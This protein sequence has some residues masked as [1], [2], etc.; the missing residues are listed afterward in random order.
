MKKTALLILC[1]LPLLSGCG[2]LRAQ[3]REVEQLRLA[4]TLGLDPAP[5]GLILSLAAPGGSEES[6]LFVR[7]SGPTVE[8]AMEALR[9]RSAEQELFCGHLQHILLGEAFAE[10]G[11]DA[12]LAAVCRSP[13]LR[14]DM[15]VYLVL[16]AAAGDAMEQAEDGETGVCDLLNGLSVRGGT[17]L[18][19]AGR[20]LRDLDR[21]GSAL[22][23]ALKQEES[24]EAGS[25]AKVLVP[26]GF[27]VLTG[28]Q[29]RERIPPEAALA[30]ELLTG[31]LQPCP[32]LLRDPQN[33]RVTLELQAGETE[34]LPL[35]DE[36]GRLTGL[37]LRLQVQASVLE[38]QGFSRAADPRTLNT[39]T[40]AL[41]REVSRRAGR[42]LDLS[43]DLQADF[44]GLGR[45]LE[46]SSPV[47]CRGLSRDLG[48]LLP[49]LYL[50]ITVQAELRH[51]NDLN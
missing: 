43:R 11:L 18:S 39:L 13:D 49:G 34:L 9:E 45:R 36:G 48:A 50:R 4:E 31:E 41:E 46:L 1:L 2:Q 20:I 32:L 30:V 38:I 22:I 40:A 21:Q 10:Q 29:L 33:R 19:T 7:A 47:R 12:L 37:E 6:P 28:G 15:P 27:G 51:S 35:W 14:V 23:R 16:D 8:T 17:G 25:E 3:S 44:L 5:E 24:P 26:W 42:V